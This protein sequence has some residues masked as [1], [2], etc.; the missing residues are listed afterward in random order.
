VIKRS[1][2]LEVSIISVAVFIPQF[3]SLLSSLVAINILNYVELSAYGT[4]MALLALGTTLAMACQTLVASQND[5]L[6]E[7][8]SFQSHVFSRAN[9]LVFIVGFVSSPLILFGLQIKFSMMISVL[10]ITSA[11]VYVSIAEGAYLG[12][13]S[14]KDFARLLFLANTSR[15]VGALVG[16]IIGKNAISAAIGML[17]G[18]FIALLFAPRIVNSFRG[19]SVKAVSSSFGVKRLVLQTSGLLSFY[20]LY[21]SD[22]LVARWFL[23]SNISGVYISGNVLTKIVFFIS[24]PLLFLAFPRMKGDSGHKIVIL[25]FIATLIICSAFVVSLYTWPDF[26]AELLIGEKYQIIS[27]YI[28]M[29]GLL[30]MLL[31]LT[32]VLIF[33]QLARNRNTWQFIC[34]IVVALFFASGYM[35]YLSSNADVLKAAILFQLITLGTLAFWSFSRQEFVTKVRTR[36][37]SE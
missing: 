10:L 24:A 22:I 32:Q 13:G 33:G 25:T 35:G 8:Y 29:Y 15:I 5:E 6:R 2:L 4:F 14:T 11:V 17:T 27:E 31:A 36:L 34:W 37:K 18:S 9:F 16:I 19:S 30:G 26:I 7:S 1:H 28:W 3:L 21:S 20:I 23:D 12:S